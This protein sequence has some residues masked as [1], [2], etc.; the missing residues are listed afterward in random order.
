LSKIFNDVVF[1]GISWSRDESKICFVGE[2]PEVASY[3][4][5]FDDEKKKEEKEEE[6][7]GEDTEAAKDKKEDEAEEHW[8]D[9]KFL[10][11][12]D[13]GEMLVGKKTP[14]I[15]VFNLRENTIN[16]VEGLEDDLYPQRPIFDESN[17]GL[18][19]SGVKLPF[20]KLGLIYCLNRPT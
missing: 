15:F 9:E 11:K 17:K 13:F 2:A 6:K 7:K 10:Y 4:N 3:K 12:E 5:P 8:Q 20:K 16:K 1:G 18:V 14:A 19:F